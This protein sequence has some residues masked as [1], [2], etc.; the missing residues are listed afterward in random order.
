MKLRVDKIG[1]EQLDNIRH[2][3]LVLDHFVE[4]RPLQGLAGYA[5]WRMN[6][7]LSRLVLRGWAMGGPSETLLMPATSR[8]NVDRVL[9]VGLGRRGE[10]TPEA[11]RLTSLHI[12]RSL[13]GLGVSRFALGIPGIS[14]LKIGTRQAVDIVL[15]SLQQMY[16]APQGEQEPPEV[17]FLVPEKNLP[18]VED[19]IQS[20][21]LNYR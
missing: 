13:R 21:A 6:G 15:T 5:D 4:D 8:L 2:D 20:F 12:M 11:L 10:Y 18:D 16:M 9:L 7:W 3:T 17:T 1:F 19:P 14:G